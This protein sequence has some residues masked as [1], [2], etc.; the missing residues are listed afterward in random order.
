MYTKH[1]VETA[2]FGRTRFEG[3]AVEVV[4]NRFGGSDNLNLVVNVNGVCV[5]RATLQGA[6]RPDVEPKAHNAARAA[7]DIFVVRT[8]E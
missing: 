7:Q 8:V 1:D 2:P 6:F 4:S 5:Y 3:T